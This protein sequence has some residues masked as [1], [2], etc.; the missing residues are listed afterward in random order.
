GTPVGVSHFCIGLLDFNSDTALSILKQRST[1]AQKAANGGIEFRDPDRIKVEL[2]CKAMSL[3]RKC[4]ACTTSLGA[5]T[6]NHLSGGARRLTRAT[7]QPK[8]GWALCI[9]WV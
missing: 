9:T 6:P 1:D 8:I 5:S 7:Q 4:S 2:R 3:P